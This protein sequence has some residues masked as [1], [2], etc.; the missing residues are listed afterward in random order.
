MVL[1]EVLV[2]LVTFTFVMGAILTLVEGLGQQAPKDEE[3]ALAL[4]EAQA[5]MHRMTR[6]LRMAYKV[7]DAQPKS[8]YVLIARSTPPDIHVKY[9]CDVPYPGNTAYRRCV[10]W[11][12][13][14]GQFL[15]VWQPGEV[16]IDRG[17]SEVNFGYSP[18]ALAPTY[19]TLHIEVPQKGERKSGYSTKFNLNDGFYLR[20][21]DVLN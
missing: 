13:P 4:R 17:L 9:D 18:S 14:V 6:E 5:G 10:R 1:A 8:M 7:L 21:T 16:V 2:T 3:R 15:P 19:V 12:A 20:N 11:A